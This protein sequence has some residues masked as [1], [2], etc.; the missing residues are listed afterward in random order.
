MGFSRSFK[1]ARA[2]LGGLVFTLIGIYKNQPVLIHLRGS[3]RAS[4]ATTARLVAT[5]PMVP[6]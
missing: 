1:L 4:H 6:A 5:I 2:W 3:C